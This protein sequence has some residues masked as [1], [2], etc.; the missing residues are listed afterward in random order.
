MYCMDSGAE[1]HASSEEHLFSSVTPSNVRMEQADGTPIEAFGEGIVHGLPMVGLRRLAFKGILSTA[2][3]TDIGANNIGVLY[4]RDGVHVV[5]HPALL[6]AITTTHGS[7]VASGPRVGN[8]YMMDPASIGRLSRRIREFPNA[9]SVSFPRLMLQ[10]ARHENR[11]QIAHERLNH[12]PFDALRRLKNAGLLPGVVFTDAEWRQATSR[13]CPGCAAGKTKKRPRPLHQ[14]S[15]P[16]TRALERVHADLGSVESSFGPDH[17]R[18]TYFLLIVDEFTRAK[19]IYFLRRK[20]DTLAAFQLWADEATRGVGVPTVVV[21]FQDPTRVDA[22]R[23]DNGG[24]FTSLEFREYWRRAGT[25]LENST[26]VEGHTFIAERNIDVVK[27]NVAALLASSGLPNQW[28]SHA[29]EYFV[30]TD[31]RVPRS[32]PPHMR[33]ESSASMWTGHVADLTHLRRFGSPCVVHVAKKDRKKGSYSSS[34]AGIFVGYTKFSRRYKVFVPTLGTTLETPF[35]GEGRIYERESVY[36]DENPLESVLVPRGGDALDD[37]IEIPVEVKQEPPI[38]SPPPLLHD[39]SSQ[40]QEDDHPAMPEASSQQPPAP[41]SP[42]AGAQQQQQQRELSHPALPTRRSHRVSQPRQQW[43]IADT[44]GQ[45]YFRSGPQQDPQQAAE[46]QQSPGPCPLSHIMAPS[47]EIAMRNAHSADASEIALVASNDSKTIDPQISLLSLLKRHSNLRRKTRHDPVDDPDVEPYELLVALSS[48]TFADQIPVPAT[49][50]QAIHPNNP[51]RE[52]WIEAMAA[53]KRCWLKN[54]VMGLFLP[55]SEVRAAG[56][57]IVPCKTVAKVKPSL[58]GGIGRFKIRVVA[59]GCVMIEGLDYFEVFAPAARGCTIRLLL[60]IAASLNMNLTNLDVETAFLTASLDVPVFIARPDG[61]E[62]IVPDGYCI[63][64]HGAVYGLPTSPRLFNRELSGFLRTLGFKQCISDPCLFV[65]RRDDK[66]IIIAL[67]VDD[68]IIAHD[69][70]IEPLIAELEQKYSMTNLGELKHVLGMEVI[71]DRDKRL[72]YLSQ[73]DYIDKMLRRFGLDGDKVTTHD[74]PARADAKLSVSSGKTNEHEDDD[75]F[76]DDG[77]VR[78]G[79]KLPYRSLVGSLLYLSICTRPDIAFAVGACSR[80][81]SNPRKAHWVAAKRI[82]RYVK[83]TSQIRLPL[84]GL[85]RFVH[86]W[87]DADLAGDNVH[88]CDTHKSTSSMLF[89]YGVGLVHWKSKLQATV[90]QSSVES[91]F[92][93]MSVGSNTVLWLRNTLEEL[94]FPETGS[95][96]IVTD[97]AGGVAAAKNPVNYKRLKHIDIRLHSIRERHELKLIHPVW[98]D[99]DLNIADIGTKPLNGPRFTKLRNMIFGKTQIQLP[100]RKPGLER[101]MFNKIAS[102]VGS[103]FRYR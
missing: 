7:V 65:R 33:G 37:G 8:L 93:A 21:P 53:E 32:A 81:V 68:L 91:E 56:H 27:T 76:D 31:N 60:S 103:Q 100:V 41:E 66:L 19:W 58:G 80:F 9:L 61:F 84:G 86:A 69:G 94:G 73:H 14:H 6:D 102:A 15:P 83:K 92:Y 1:L 77:E 23:T 57:K 12:M 101:E 59:K 78:S 18:R 96:P 64:L 20:S 10:N 24:E 39:P 55:T 2:L 42:S 51:Y 35:P 44:R 30:Y 98:I 38:A 79:I 87:T 16:V 11:C 5:R 99:G 62:D 48:A 45:A 89:F 70:D 40:Q 13:I 34:R 95:T 29:A 47:P 72:V 26:P 43:N 22:I 25:W 85:V 54:G 46:V 75:W 90:A 74:T 82:L 97:S 71:R 63:L 49:W 36:I 4:L 17:K 50:A 3:I 28:W 52:H 67:V 88:G